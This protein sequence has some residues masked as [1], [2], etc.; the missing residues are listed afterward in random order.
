ML[1][2][3]PIRQQHF[4]AHAVRQKQKWQQA[5][6]WQGGRKTRPP[7]PRVLN[8]VSRCWQEQTS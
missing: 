1:D 2:G 8:T 3:L 4:C 6:W 5:W 7:V